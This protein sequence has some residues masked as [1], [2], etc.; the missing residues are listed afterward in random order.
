KG[1]A[2][3][4]AVLGTHEFA[5]LDRTGSGVETIA[6]LAD[7][8]R[9][10]VMFCAF[11]GPP[12]IV[13][14]HGTGRTVLPGDDDFDALRESFPEVSWRGVRSIIHVAV[15]RVSQSCGFGV[16]FMTYDGERD[17]ME[18]WVAGKSDD[19]LVDYRRKKN[20]V[21]IDGLPGLDA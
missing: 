2:G 18:K 17:T 7:N 1:F 13:R 11:D 10:A 5:Y 20:S 12:R 14:L 9:I 21:S 19:D 6:H 4:F 8:G 3:S 15:D 16:P